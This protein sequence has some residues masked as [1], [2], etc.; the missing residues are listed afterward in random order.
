MPDQRDLVRAGILVAQGAA[1]AAFPGVVQRVEVSG[2]AEHDRAETDPDPGLVH[3]VEHRRQAL[4]GL[5]DEVAHG[6]LVLTEVEHGGSGAA[7]AH[8]VDQPGQGHIVAFAG[9]AVLIDQVLRD[10]EQRDPLNAGRRVRQACQYH[11]HDVLAELVIAPGDE[12]LVAL[13]AV[14]AIILWRCAGAQVAQRGTGMGLGQAHGSEEPTLDHGLGVTGLLGLRA[15][16]QDQVGGGHGQPGVPLGADVRA[17]EQPD[18]HLGHGS[19]QLH[20]APLIVL[21]GRHQPGL[22]E[23]AERLPDFRAHH[24]PAILEARLLFIHQPRVRGELLRRHAQGQ[25]QGRLE[26]FGT[27]IGVAFI[28]QQLLRAV[29]LEKLERQVLGVDDVLVHGTPGS[30]DLE[31]TGGALATPDAHGHHHV[32]GAT[33]F[34]LDQGMAGQA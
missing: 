13:E 26:R 32:L 20:A 15:M 17:L 23:D 18:T 14:T 19:G 1:L 3:H 11:V 12:D 5:T 31:Q 22:A 27:V 4:V 10:D 21:P 29:Q 2:I 16:G 34:A 30:D 9:G 8:L 6:T 25:V 7:I 33:A 28:V 24:H